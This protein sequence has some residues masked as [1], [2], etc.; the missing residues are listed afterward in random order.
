MTFLICQLEA[1]LP[2]LAHPPPLLSGVEL[3]LD[4]LRRPLPAHAACGGLRERRQDSQVV[5]SVGLDHAHSHNGGLRLPSLLRR[6]LH[7]LVSA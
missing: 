7:K 2:I 1:H 5:L 3:L 6:L 4:V